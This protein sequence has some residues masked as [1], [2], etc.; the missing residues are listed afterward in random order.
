MH[1]AH[2][3]EE[4]VWCSSRVLSIFLWAAVLRGLVGGLLTL[5]KSFPSFPL[6][7]SLFSEFPVFFSICRSFAVAEFRKFLYDDLRNKLRNSQ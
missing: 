3:L 4:E 7:V 1:I 2:F 6:I 5:M